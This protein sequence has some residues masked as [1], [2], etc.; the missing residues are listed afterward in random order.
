MWFVG[1]AGNYIAVLDPTSGV[2]RRYEI[3]PGTYPHNLI[4][5]PDGMVW[6]A[7][8]QTPLLPDGG[9]G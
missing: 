7:G 6:Y 9:G 8:N 2:F 4:V 3:D 1:Q 5:A